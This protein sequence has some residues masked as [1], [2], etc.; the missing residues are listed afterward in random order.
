MRELEFL[1]GIW[2]RMPAPDFCWNFSEATWPEDIWERCRHHS[3]SALSFFYRQGFEADLKET[4]GA[5]AKVD[6]TST[7]V[8]NVIA[9]KTIYNMK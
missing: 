1:K 4:V 6:K 2:R 7:G 3:G 9:S 8:Q 5:V